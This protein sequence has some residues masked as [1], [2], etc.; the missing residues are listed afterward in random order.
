MA[1]KYADEFKAQVIAGWKAGDSELQLAERYDVPRT[2]LQ[3][4]LKGHERA[5]KTSLTIYDYDAM[6][7]RLIDGSISA[8]GAIQNIASDKSWLEGQDAGQVAILYGV[9][10]DKLY[11]VLGAIRR[12]ESDEPTGAPEPDFAGVS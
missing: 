8:L 9:I 4:W 11:R 5:T 7:V 2:T 3:K 10:A 1:S 6:A 12:P